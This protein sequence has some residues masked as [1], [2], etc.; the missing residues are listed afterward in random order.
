MRGTHFLVD[1]HK[2]DLPHITCIFHLFKYMQS[3]IFLVSAI[4]HHISLLKLLPKSYF[5]ISTFQPNFLCSS[6]FKT[7]KSYSQRLVFNEEQKSNPYVLTSLRKDDTKT[8]K[9]FSF[10]SFTNKL[11][12]QVDIFYSKNMAQ[13]LLSSNM[14][15]T[16]LFVMPNS[17]LLYWFSSFVEYKITFKG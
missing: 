9:Q 11:L 14:N 16:V 3:R 5:K 2:K 1:G 15:P 10:F 13:L 4:L 17:K 12:Q 8:T 6:S 7:Q